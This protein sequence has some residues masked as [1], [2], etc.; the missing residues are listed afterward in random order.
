MRVSFQRSPIA[1]AALLAL[2]AGGAL[3]QPAPNTLPV[4]RPGGALINATVGTPSGNTLNVT[5]TGSASNRGLIEWSSFS[6]GSAARVN[7]VQPNG[8]SVLV[9]RVVGSGTGG[10]SASEIY[11]A[12]NANGRVF[13]VNPSGVVFGGSA[14][15]NVGSLVATSLD[16]DSATTANNYQR[17]M[18]GGAIVLGSNGTGG[19]IQVLAADDASRP[20]IQV[21]EGGSI[22]L[23]SPTQLLQGGSIAAAGGRI[24]L[25]S[26]GGATLLPVGESGFIDVALQPGAGSV[27]LG[28]RSLTV[29]SGGGQVSIQGDHIRLRDG[30]QVLADGAAGGGRIDVG[31]DST[32]SIVAERG[33]LLSADATE[34]GN[35]GSVKLLAMYNNQAAAPAA[36]VDYGVTEAYGLIRAR[37]GVNSGNGGQVETSGAAVNTRLAAADGTL[38]H[39]GV[40]DASARAAGGQSGTWTLDPYNVTISDATATVNPANGSF[41]PSGPGANVN[42]A[43]LSAALNAGTNVEITTG[44]AQAGTEAGNITLLRDTTVTRTAGGGTATLTLRAHNDI[45]LDVGSTL[46]GSTGNGLNVN[47][48]SNLDGVGA[49]SV[50]VGGTVRTFGG[51]VDIGGGLTPA[52][53]YARSNGQTDGVLLSGALID[54]RGATGRGNVSMRGETPSGAATRGVTI[55]ESTVIANDISISGRSSQGAGVALGGSFGVPSTLDTASGLISV[56]GFADGLVSTGADTT[57]VVLENLEVSLGSAGSLYVAGRSNNQSS[58]FGLAGVRYRNT[59]IVAATNSTGTITLAGEITGNAGLGGLA[60]FNAQ[61]APL[62]I[63][64][65]VVN[66]VTQATGAHVVLGG[67]AEQGSAVDLGFGFGTDIR[68]NGVVNLRPLGVDTAGNLVEQPG[69]AI[70]IGTEASGGAFF[71]DSNWLATPNAS[72]SGISAGRGVVIG[73]SLHTGLIT[74]EDSALN[75]HADVSLTLQNQ[76]ASSA[77]I[78]LRSGNTLQNLG[79]RTSGNITQTGAITVTGNLVI[80]GGAQTTVALTDTGNSVGNLAFDPPASFT[81]QTTG[82]LSIGAAST[83]G[84]T[85]GTGFAPLSITNSLGGNT[86]LI[87]STGTITLNQSISMVGANAQLNLVAPSITVAPGAGVSAPAGGSAKMWADTFTGVA[88]GTNLYGCVYGDTTNCSVSGITL[89]TTGN[90]LLHSTQPTLVVTANPLTGYLDLA[91]PA[92]SFSTTGLLNGDTAAGALAGSL[93]TTPTGTGTYAISQGNLRSPLGYNLTFTPSTLTLRPGITR[94]MLQSSFQA[95]LASDVYGRNLD[96]PYICTAASVL[97]GTLADDK[98][99]DPL[100]SEWGKV[101]NQP[102]LSGCLNVTDGGS[103]SAF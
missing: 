50:F 68:T 81:L 77:G 85:P 30:S 63:S 56:R 58:S 20:Q 90:Q 5:Q 46:Q 28:G 4:Q 2:G 29:A 35:G 13:L 70:T 99:T 100:A 7:I 57:G 36:R 49:G 43:D 55:S 18:N 23:V 60:F 96:Q 21:S 75:Q 42:A 17:L 94:Q 38:T 26:A 51:N 69:R 66:G 72:R 54:T 16:L 83:A 86:A 9:N 24:H 41:V 25:A 98:Q 33:S 62:T 14:Q 32:R 53:G 80:E 74:V 76:G 52:T 48:Y 61:S 84:Y 40:V 44:T 1:L 31:N 92:L 3:A 64:A 78:E 88:P 87:Q 102:Q 19:G 101:R 22:V 95:E 89:P 93:A 27:E 79:L 82:P 71:I 103:C 65:G 39:R 91:L 8:Q 67:S 73:S 47:L 6:I 15:V 11:G 97:R 12:L 59:N 37:G 10:P 34:A 45:V